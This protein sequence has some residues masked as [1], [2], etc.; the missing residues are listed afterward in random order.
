MNSVSNKRTLL[1]V[2]PADL[3]V[4]VTGAFVLQGK[5]GDLIGLRE[6]LV[7]DP[8]FKVIYKTNSSRHLRI[9]PEDDFLLIKKLKEG[10]DD[11]QQ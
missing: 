3:E 1:G 11:E 8:R 10:Q 7:K 5:L 4:V 2:E 9:V 6:Q